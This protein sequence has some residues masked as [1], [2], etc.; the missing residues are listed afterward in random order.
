MAVVFKQLQ[1]L[2]KRVTIAREALN[3]TLRLWMKVSVK[4][5]M[6]Q[7]Y[8]IPQDSFKVLIPC[9]SEIAVTDPFTQM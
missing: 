5:L 8:E 4:G 3:D 9:I 1:H 6:A 2:E 7:D